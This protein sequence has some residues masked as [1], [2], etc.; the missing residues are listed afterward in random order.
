M[1]TDRNKLSCIKER[2]FTLIEAMVVASVLVFGFVA[3]N[4]V[5]VNMVKAKHSA[6]QGSQAVLLSNQEIER[7]RN[8]S[9]LTDY[10]N[11]SSGSA[12]TSA[13]NTSYNDTLTITTLTR[14]KKLDQTLSWTDSS[15]QSQSI[16]LSSFINQGDPKYSGLLFST[17]YNTTPLPS[18]GVGISSGGGS[19]TDTGSTTSTTTDVTV[20]G[21]DIVLTYDSNNQV[22][23]INHTAAVTL[24][25]NI[26]VGTG[27]NDPGNGVSLSA[28]TVT[29][30]TS[31]NLV[32]TCSYSGS[33]G[34]LSCF[35]ARGWSGS[36]L[37]GGVTGTN[38]CV[39]TA[40]PYTNLLT[41][42]TNQNYALIKS[43][44]SCPSST[45]ILL[46]SL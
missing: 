1:N 28:V 40:Q 35:M 18:P 21:T 26:T 5:Q 15:G 10:A 34:V 8:Y 36:I 17:S 31:N 20:P 19:G 33:T 13:A 3:A 4:K 45:S 37:L 12:T 6:T 42:L 23:Q 22:I 32:V 38:V 24:S 7:L 39:V 43:N 14:Y 30:Q 27:G 25:G 11:I 16:S 41:S 9:N 29:P 44:Q 46:Q 2:G